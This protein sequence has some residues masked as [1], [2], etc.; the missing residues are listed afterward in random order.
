MTE[1]IIIRHGETEW[2]ITGR[3]Q[4]HS[5]IPL[6][7]AG[8]EQAEL[9]GKNIALDGID[10]IYASDLIRA[11]ETAQPL[12]ARFRLPVEKD[13]AL[14]ELNFGT[15]EG[16]YFSEINEETPDLMKQFYRD[17]ES[18]DIPGIE[19]FQEFRRRVAGRVREIAAQNKG[20]RIV[21]ISHGASIRILFADILS[22]P[23][24]AI[25]HV[26]QFNTAVNRI[27]F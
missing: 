3:F 8:H 21:L 9:L 26:S 23:V 25:W 18:I 14:R 4:G 13:E 16:R 5:D 22:M 6:S 7:A 10:K 12:A 27:R 2:N 17:P 11:V 24:R 15:W 19:N 1:I 20:R